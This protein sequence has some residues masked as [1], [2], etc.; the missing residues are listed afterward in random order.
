[1]LVALVVLLLAA[2]PLFACPVVRA[3]VVVV[4]G[5]VWSRGHGAVPPSWISGSIDR[6]GTMFE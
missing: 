2:A 4:A 3:A 6:C 5:T 1:M